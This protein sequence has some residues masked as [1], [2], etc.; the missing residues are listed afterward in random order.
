MPKKRGWP[1]VVGAVALG[2]TA[3]L[4][5]V[6]DPLLLPGDHEVTGYAVDDAI[7]GEVD[8]APAHWC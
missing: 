4:A 8:N 5:V 7:S 6:R 2:A 3:V 1:W